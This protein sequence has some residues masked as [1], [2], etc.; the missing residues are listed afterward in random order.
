MSS[1]PDAPATGRNREAILEVLRSEF[2]DRR[3]VLEIGSGTGQHAVYF[4]PTL[5]HLTWHTS[6][7]REN[8]DGINAW[9]ARAG[10]DNLHAPIELDVSHADAT[11]LRSLGVDAVFSANT[12]HIMSADEVEAMFRLTGDLLSPGGLFCLYGPFRFDGEFTST[13]NARFDASLKQQDPSMGIR[14]IEALD[15]Y[16]RN[17]DMFRVR[18]YAM[19]ANNFIA[20]W[21]KN[22][23]GA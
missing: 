16:A 14:D 20:V 9:V 10:T 5:D 15:R 7:V 6:D 22:G 3:S 4:S 11:G 18:L 12:A 19:P 1:L 8:L 21:R 13:S 2:R 17:C 23:A